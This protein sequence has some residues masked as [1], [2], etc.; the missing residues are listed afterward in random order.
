M[1]KIK[2]RN[3]PQKPATPVELASIKRLA[4]VYPENCRFLSQNYKPEWFLDRYEEEYAEWLEKGGG[5]EALA[6]AKQD[7]KNS[8]KAEKK[9]SKSSSKS[10][11][12]PSKTKSYSNAGTGGAFKSAEF[13]QDSD[14]D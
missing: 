7:K 11:S 10:T 8:K 3:I 5:K 12:S 1:E 2:L 14:S 9:A 4:F 13:I 6:Q